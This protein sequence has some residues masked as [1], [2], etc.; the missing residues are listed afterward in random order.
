MKRLAAF[1]LALCLIPL[2][3][4]AKDYTP[5]HQLAETWGFRFGGAMIYA[6]LQDENF[7]AFAAHHYN[8][9]TPTNEMKAYSLLD[10]A[11]SRASADGMPAMNYVRAD[12]MIAWAQA[13]GMHVR[14]HVLVWDAYMT[15]WFFHEEYDMNRPVADRETMR[16]RLR[17]YITDVMTHFETKFPGVVDCW[18]VVNEAVGDSE[19]EWAPKDK[20]HVRTVR[21]GEKNPFYHYVGEDYVEFA[22]LC[23]RDTADA[24]GADIRLYYNDYNAFSLPKC[25][26]VCELVE[27]INSYA[28]DERGQPRVLID[29]VGMQGYVGGYGVQEGC[30]NPTDLNRIRMAVKNY[31]KAGVEVQFTEMAVRN[32]DASRAEEHAAFYGDMAALLRDMNQDGRVFT[33]WTIWGM[34]DYAHLPKTDYT[35]I[36]NSPWGG[37]TDRYYKPKPAFDAVY[38]A[39]GGV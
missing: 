33:A 14:G 35:W 4:S 39:L 12:E 10:L 2:C 5:M 27:S 19:G 37:L 8:T 38:S 3:A 21:G 25:R 30:L 13:Q 31:V 24:L 20:R 36:L 15:P 23:A 29:G 32:Y 9:V 34:T 28:V 6:A 7:L 11:A 18:D 16:A 17:H 22:F 26:A 1:V